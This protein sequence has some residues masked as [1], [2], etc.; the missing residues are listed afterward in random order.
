MRLG[1]VFELRWDRVDHDAMTLRVEDTKTGE[2]LVLPIVR[3]VAAIL[4]RRLAGRDRFPEQCRVWVFPS[5]TSQSGRIA[6]L[7]HL[8]G[9]IGEAGGARF[10]FHA[11]RNCFITV[12]DRELMLPTSL[13]KRLV[14]HARP[15]D[16]TEGYAAD[17]TMQQLRDAAQSIA[18]KIDKLIGAGI[19]PT[20]NL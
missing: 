20:E 4:E 7:Q 19:P 1:E 13:T 18:D 10:W 17:W 2:P 5:E 11:L 14:N 3:Q 15:S 16:V 12:A 6:S 8:N 9:R